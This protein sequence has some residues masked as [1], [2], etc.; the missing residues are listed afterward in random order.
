MTLS[1]YPP[2]V[3]GN[4]PQIAGGEDLYL[5]CV[6]GEVFDIIEIAAEHAETCPEQGGDRWQFDIQPESEAL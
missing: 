4:E 1:N 5:V 3:S 6:C 2:G